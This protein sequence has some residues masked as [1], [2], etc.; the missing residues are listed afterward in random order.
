[1]PKIKHIRINDIRYDLSTTIRNVDGL[2]EELDKQNSEILEIQNDLDGVHGDLDG[3]HEDLDKKAEEILAIQNDLDGVHGDLDGI[4]G[5]LDKKSG[6]ILKIQG[7]LSD[8]QDDIDTKYYDYTGIKA[9][10]I[11]KHEDDI[12]GLGKEIDALKKKIDELPDGGGGGSV[13][14]VVPVTL[15]GTGKTSVT[16]NNFLV[17]NGQSTLQEKTPAQV[18]T[19]I[20]GASASEVEDLKTSVSDGKSAIASAIT[21]KG[22][23]TSGSETFSS[24]ADKIRQ[25]SS[26]T[27]V[28]KDDKLFKS[29]PVEF[30]IDDGSGDMSELFGGIRHIT[31]GRNSLNHDIFV[32]QSSLND[33]IYSVDGYT[34][35]FGISEL[36]FNVSGIVYG[37]DKFVAVF[38]YADPSV[39]PNYKSA[40]IIFTSLNGKTWEPTNVFAN[41]VEQGCTGVAY[42][43][44][45]YVAITNNTNG[46]YSEDGEIWTFTNGMFPESDNWKKVIYANEKFVAIGDTY[47]A[48]SEDGRTFT[49]INNDPFISDGVVLQDIAYGEN[50]Y[51]IIAKHGEDDLYVYHR[52][53]D[54][55][56]YL[57]FQ[58]V[59]ST[60]IEHNVT[61]INEQSLTLADCL[62]VCWGNGSFVILCNQIVLHSSDGVKW[63]VETKA[64]ETTSL[65]SELTW[66]K[67]MFLTGSILDNQ[68]YIFNTSS[69]E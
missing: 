32:A 50:H 67:G 26:G 15:G 44:G 2:R 52:F 18:L 8:I 36:N 7:D 23:S 12:D 65:T 51:V 28:V 43:N 53:G 57:S 48:Y 29:Y 24:M 19:L 56:Q 49:L 45:K 1:M 46:W 35:E 9:I 47:V 39:F 31:F 66:N 10:V 34:W 41:S 30:D 11:N 40:N 38:P 6:E 21:D 64:F 5:D 37:K 63:E 14:E 61:T 42:G 55:N 58:N 4:H 25:I 22:V 59:Y 69:F 68:I 17:G 33:M 54:V 62:S 20:G 27:I 3:I 16:E 60:S 13:T